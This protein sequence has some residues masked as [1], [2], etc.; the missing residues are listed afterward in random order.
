MKKLIL[1]PTLFFGLFLFDTLLHPPN[2]SAQSD[3]CGEL[4]QNEI[5]THYSLY[6]EDYKN[7]SYDSALPNL[8]W[9]LKCAPGFPNHKAR[10]FERTWKLY[11]G[12]SDAATDEAI[13]R[14]YLDTALTIFD[15]TVSIIKGIGGV[16]DEW[17]WI[18]EKGR[19]IQKN[20][21]KLPDLQDQVGPIYRTAYDMDPSR[22]SNYYIDYIIR[23]YIS[24]EDKEG[25]VDFM[26]V[27]EQNSSDNTELM[28]II[29]NW[30]DVMFKDPEERVDFVISRIEKNPDDV[31]LHKELFQ[32]Y[33][34]L[35]MRDE[36]VEEA[37]TLMEI[38]PTPE[39]FR[40][41][42]KMSLDDGDY[43]EAIDLFTKAITMPGGET[44]ARDNYYNIG[45]A[46]QNLGHFSKARANYRKSLQADPKFGKAYVAIANL[47]STTVQNCG[48]FDRLD[49]AVYWLVTDYYQKAKSVDPSLSNSAKQHVREFKKYYPTA[50]DRFFQ[51]WEAGKPYK[52]NYGCYSW[53]NETTTVKE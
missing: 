48:T 3:E 47:Y 26:D 27:V 38:A 29:T 6:Y 11:Q 16:V 39:I 15:T 14:A 40:L 17:N 51:K 24:K 45:I 5:A 10:N 33:L 8:K 19:F 25:A 53:I 36:A 49:R 2:A 44:Y 43:Q 30:R 50:E 18:F 9:I 31:D 4:T 13:S 28:T 34:E 23:D 21:E 22:V 52:V 42:G 7:K 12:L 37:R 46:E 41:V 35:D 20:A 32:L 1:V